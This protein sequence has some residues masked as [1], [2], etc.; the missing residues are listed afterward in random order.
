MFI[1]GL[2]QSYP[3]IGTCSI[4]REPSVFLKSTS[5]QTQIRISQQLLLHEGTQG[6][7]L[8]NARSL[9]QLRPRIQRLVVDLVDDMVE[10]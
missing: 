5:V 3:N 1:S 6:C 10:I 4:L 9:L 2:C 7:R 8:T